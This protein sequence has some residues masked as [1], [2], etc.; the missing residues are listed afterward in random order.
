MGIIDKGKEKVERTMTGIK[1]P[2]LVLA[3]GL[4]KTIGFAT[5]VATVA[6]IGAEPSSSLFSKVFLGPFQVM[7]TGYDVIGAYATNQGIRDFS[8]GVLGDLMHLVGNA[9]QN[10]YENPS[11]TLIAAGS[12]YVIGSLAKSAISLWRE[13]KIDGYQNKP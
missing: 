3:S 11:G 7:Q 5:P 13:S 9:A 2:S 12:T 6:T 10:I 8:N 1:R 4:E